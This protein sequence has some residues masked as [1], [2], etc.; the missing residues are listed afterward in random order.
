[1]LVQILIDENDTIN[2]IVRVHDV[3]VEIIATVVREADT[4]ALDGLHL[5]RRSAQCLD[6]GQINQLCEEFCRHYGVDRLVIRGA[7]RTTG[8]SAGRIPRPIVYRLPQP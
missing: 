5:D 8:K 1:M 4:I 3:A 7:R 2:A 6:R